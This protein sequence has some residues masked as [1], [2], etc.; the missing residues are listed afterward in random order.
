VPYYCRVVFLLLAAATAVLLVFSSDQL[1]DRLPRLAERAE[2]RTERPGTTYDVVIV[3]GGLVDAGATRSSGGTRLSGAVGRLLD[4]WEVVRTGT[5][6]HLL[7]SGGGPE[8]QTG[9]EAEAVLAARLLS[10]W[11]VPTDRI[12]LGGASR[13]TRESALES[14]RIV[15]ERGWNRVLL[16]TSAAHMERALGCFHA[17]GPR[18]DARPVEYRGG[19]GRGHAWLPRASALDKGTDAIHEMAGRITYRIMGYSADP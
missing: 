7:C 1:A 13:N 10:G 17:A 6:R 5:A 11:G 14:A 4:G 18:P 16:V 2:V 9:V 19:H 3:L 12:L 15:G 8:P